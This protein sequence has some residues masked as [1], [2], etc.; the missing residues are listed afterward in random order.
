MLGKVVLNS[1]W[2]KRRRHTTYTIVLCTYEIHVQCT[3]RI[4]FAQACKMSTAWRGNSEATLNRF[5]KIQYM[6][7][8][9]RDRNPVVN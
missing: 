5:L 7:R 6:L 9:R 2:A 4:K 3:L 8:E 1:P